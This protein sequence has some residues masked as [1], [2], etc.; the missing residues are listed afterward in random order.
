MAD[1]HERAPNPPYVPFS[2]FKTLLLDLRGHLP[3]KV[4][5]SVLRTG[6]SGSVANGLQTGLRFLGLITADDS[7]T[8]R[9]RD[10]TAADEGQMLL[11]LKTVLDEAYGGA[12]KLDELKDMTRQHFE[13]KFNSLAAPG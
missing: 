9:L 7:P 4:D 13:T 8:Q 6:R 3:T 10:V 1:E 2:A 5:R 12:I 11:T